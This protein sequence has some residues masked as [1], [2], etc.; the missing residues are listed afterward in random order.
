MEIVGYR[1][2][3]ATKLCYHS[4][5]EPRRFCPVLPPHAFKPG[6]FMEDPLDR[7][8]DLAAPDVDSTQPDRRWP[9]VTVALLFAALAA[10]S[11]G[12]FLRSPAVPATETK[13]V[14]ETIVDLPAPNAPNA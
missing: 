10:L 3:C 5:A 11:V 13:S 8:I 7:E 1:Q 14:S 6:V 4:A 12:L 2:E 9:I